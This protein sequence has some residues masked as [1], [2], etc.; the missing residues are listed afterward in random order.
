MEILYSAPTKSNMAEKISIGLK[1]KLEKMFDVYSKFN[2]QNYTSSAPQTTFLIL[3][4]SY[5]A[6]TPL[7]RD[8]HYL[9]LLY[10]YKNCNKHKIEDRGKVYIMDDNDPIF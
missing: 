7:I 2:I 1:E 6:I 3:D 5:D 9:P 8:F 4:R 10:D